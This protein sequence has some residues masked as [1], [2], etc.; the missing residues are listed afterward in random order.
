MAARQ[1]GT[2]GLVRLNDVLLLKS[3]SLGFNS[4]Y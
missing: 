2:S 3:E 4:R 1:T